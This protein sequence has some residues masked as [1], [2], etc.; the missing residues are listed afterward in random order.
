M[1][2]YTYL[3]L[4]LLSSTCLSAPFRYTFPI[5]TDIDINKFYNHDI[6]A[7]TLKDSS[8]TAIFDP[9]TSAFRDLDTTLTVST[10]I[11][12]SNNTYQHT[13]R[14]LDKQNQCFDNNGTQIL[15]SK[16]QDSFNSLY[17]SNTWVP[18]NTDVNLGP[19]SDVVN[20]FK[21]QSHSLSLRFSP[22]DT[23][24]VR[25]CEGSLLLAVSLDV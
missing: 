20:G 10:S 23:T 5:T 15:T 12:I 22:V 25:R 17:I 14:I 2:K 8:M 6:T 18:S 16:Q 3:G 9:D 13:I 11:P 7:L 4:L 24:T 1:K 21:A 19:F